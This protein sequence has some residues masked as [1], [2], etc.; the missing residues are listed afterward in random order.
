MNGFL[1]PGGSAALRPGHSFF[2]TAAEVVRLAKLANQ[3][4][5]A[6]PILGI[7][8]GFEALA[9]ITSG[10]TSIMS[11]WGPTFSMHA[12]CW[13]WL[14]FTTCITSMYHKR[15]ISWPRLASATASLRGRSIDG[16]SIQASRSCLLCS[17]WLLLC[18]AS[19]VQPLA[20][21]D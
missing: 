20:Q 15:E 11:R 21:L 10:N 3:Q 18:R 2:D 16:G 13:V 12:S 7:C 4:G 9:I 1:I 19:R 17:A 5:D 6:F 14:L 8:L